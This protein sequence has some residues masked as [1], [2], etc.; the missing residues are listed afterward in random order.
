M[1]TSVLRTLNRD[2]LTTILDVFGLSLI[3]AAAA[4]WA[5]VALALVVAGLAVLAVSWS[6]SRAPR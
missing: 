1:L 6:L 5:G 2:T 3:V 4:V